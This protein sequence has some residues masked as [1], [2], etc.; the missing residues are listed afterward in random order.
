MA[1][2]T[3]FGKLLLSLKSSIEKIEAKNIN[4]N[5][6]RD[7][8]DYKSSENMYVIDTYKLSLRRLQNMINSFDTQPRVN[9]LIRLLSYGD[10]TKNKVIVGELEKF[11]VEMMPQTTLDLRKLPDEV[12]EEVKADLDELDKCMKHGCYRSSVVLCGRIIEVC[13]HAKYYKVTGFDILEKN[14]GIGLG[15]LIAKME[16]KNI[17]LDPGLTQQI[18]LVNNVRIFSV[19]KKQRVFVPTKQQT[20]AI[21]LY[22]LDVVSKLF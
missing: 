9:E 3:E 1:K 14:P 17:K 5:E 19:H 12:R 7:F 2:E 13:L 10:V 8:T 4:L 16:E 22:T 15:T 6:R 21:V 20:E 11:D 18:H